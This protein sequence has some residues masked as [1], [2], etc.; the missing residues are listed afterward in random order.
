MNYILEDVYCIHNIYVYLSLSIYPS[1]YLSI[2]LPTT[3]LVSIYPH[4][5]L[6]TAGQLWTPWRCLLCQAFSRLKALLSSCCSFLGLKRPPRRKRYA[7]LEGEEGLDLT[8]AP[9]AEDCAWGLQRGRE[10]EVA[11]RAE[12]RRCASKCIGRHDLPTCFPLWTSC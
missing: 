2:N 12:A 9:G 3:Y 5:C 11:E 8:P 6:S 10:A 7:P 1:T 4:T